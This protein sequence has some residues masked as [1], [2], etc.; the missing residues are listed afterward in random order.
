[1]FN[2]LMLIK[3]Q[4][5]RLGIYWQNPSFEDLVFQYNVAKLL[6]QDRTVPFWIRGERFRNDDIFRIRGGVSVN[7]FVQA[8]PAGNG[9]YFGIFDD[10]LDI[11]KV[12]ATPSGVAAKDNFCYLLKLG[13]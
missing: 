1:M 8:A 13:V 5:M 10:C 7:K 11:N 2:L 3:R 6:C 4:I 12:A 9:G